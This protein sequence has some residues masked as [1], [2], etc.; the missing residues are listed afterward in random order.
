MGTHHGRSLGGSSGGEGVRR[1]FRSSYQSESKEVDRGVRSHSSTKNI[2]PRC[3]GGGVCWWWRLLVVAFVGG[4][5]GG[6]GGSSY[7]RGALEAF[8]F[9]ASHQECLSWPTS[10]VRC[11][12]DLNARY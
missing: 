5:V 11:N 3:D 12:L 1:I 7:D 9:L 2:L 10:L 4:G 8:Y 6:C